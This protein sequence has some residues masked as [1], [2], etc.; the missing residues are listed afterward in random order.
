M[1][2]IGTDKVLERCRRHA[3]ASREKSEEEEYSRRCCGRAVSTSAST[4]GGG[5]KTH[6]SPAHCAFNKGGMKGLRFAVPLKAV[7]GGII[8][9][10]FPFLLGGGAH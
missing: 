5:N 6:T 7:T 10:A 8:F 3:K 4:N 9:I 2:L 1:R